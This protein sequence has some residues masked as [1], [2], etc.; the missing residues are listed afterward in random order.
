[1]PMTARS[2]GGRGLLRGDDGPCMLLDVAKLTQGCGQQCTADG[3]H[4]NGE[5]YDAV[6]HIILNALVIES[7]QR[8]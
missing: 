8:I 4:Y 6:L 3:M 2:I 7:Q 5:V 1:M